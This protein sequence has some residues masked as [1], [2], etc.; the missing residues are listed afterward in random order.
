IK[1]F[2]SPSG[3]RCSG[4]IMMRGSHS[5]VLPLHL[6]PEGLLK[7]LILP[8]PQMQYLALMLRYSVIISNQLPG[9]KHIIEGK[10]EETNWDKCTGRAIWKD[11]MQKKFPF[12][13]FF[14]SLYPVLS[15]TRCQ[16]RGQ[17]PLSLR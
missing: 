11:Q 8:S 4:S 1:V 17:K 5:P 10:T 16:R 9:L 3:G 12:F 7:T 15:F 13:V 14:L 2:K 6:P